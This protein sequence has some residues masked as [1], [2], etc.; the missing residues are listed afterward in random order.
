ME[1]SNLSSFVSKHDRESLLEV[2][3]EYSALRTLIG[4]LSTKLTAVSTHIEDEFLSSY[5]VHMLSVQQELRDLKVQVIKAEEA[6]NED[7]QVAA[8]EQEMTWFCDESTRLKNQTTSMKKDMQHIVM[9]TQVLR[10]QRKFLSVQLKSNLKRSRILEAELRELTG[11]SRF[12]SSSVLPPPSSPRNTDTKKNLQESA[13]A[14][15]LHATINNRPLLST[16]SSSKFPSLKKKSK[17]TTMVLETSL[18]PED[19]LIPK[20]KVSNAN[21]LSFNA[22]P[23]EELEELK[24]NRSPLE[25]GLES[26]IKGVLREIVDR[27]VATAARDMRI[28]L[29]DAKTSKPRL[30][31]VGGITGL[32]LEHFSDSDRLSAISIF[33]SQPEVFKK[34]V[35][36]LNQSL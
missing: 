17:S 5:R 25:E 35:E 6:L 22:S 14:P 20:P 27:K 3:D 19:V 26:A 15:A 21:A 8:L 32:G 24:L 2:R 36:Q 18:A 1:K 34:I 33:L 13:S 9:R 23:V 11:D 4:S 28:S 30:V 12:E 10:E 31:E 7:K 29:E 16:K